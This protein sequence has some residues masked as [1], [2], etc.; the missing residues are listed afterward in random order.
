MYHKKHRAAI[1]KLTVIFVTYIDYLKSSFCAS[2]VAELSFDIKFISFS[3][4]S[5]HKKCTTK[6]K[7][8]I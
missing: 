7:M 3:R 6:I 4:N 2:L 8:K 1:N 5:T